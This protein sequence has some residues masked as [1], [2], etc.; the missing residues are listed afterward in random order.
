MSLATK[1][2]PLVY[3][4]HSERLSV[5]NLVDSGFQIKLSRI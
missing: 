4:L 5:L 3:F 1:V 2:V